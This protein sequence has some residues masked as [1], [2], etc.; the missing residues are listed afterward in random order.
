MMTAMRKGSPP[1][2]PA[3]DPGPGATLC[4][5]PRFNLAGGVTGP[6]SAPLTASTPIQIGSKPGASM[7]GK[8]NGTVRRLVATGAMPQP[9]T[10]SKAMMTRRRRAGVEP[11]GSD[12][13]DQKLRRSRGFDDAVDQWRTDREKKDHVG[14]CDGVRGAHPEHLAPV[15]AGEH[16]DDARIERS[17]RGGRKPV[18]AT[19]GAHLGYRDAA[20]IGTRRRS[21]ARSSGVL[22]VYCGSCFLFRDIGHGRC[23]GRITD[24]DAGGVP[25]V[26]IDRG[27]PAAARSA[28]NG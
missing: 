8:M 14:P 26:M 27:A 12:G 28:S 17:D 23:V 2:S 15:R 11:C 5:T 7:P 20:L 21:P 4:N 25:Q 1:R 16:A 19:G 18:A 13:A 6:T 3:P 22:P 24:T 10:R 9:R